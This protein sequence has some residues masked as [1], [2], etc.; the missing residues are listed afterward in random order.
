MNNDRFH[1]Q[2]KEAASDEEYYFYFWCLTLRNLGYIK[3][4]VF[5]PP[6]FNITPKQTY[7]YIKLMKS[8]T[9]LAE[10]TLLNPHTYQ[11]DYVIEWNK[12]AHH[13][14]F[15]ILGGA[16]NYKSKNEVLLL[17]QYRKDKIISVIDTKGAVSFAHA[18]NN[19]TVIKFPINQKLVYQKFGIYVNKVV[20]FA[21]NDKRNCL[22]SKT[23]TPDEY[24]Y[25]KK[26]VGGGYLKVNCIPRTINE[27]LNVK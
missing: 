9:K 8:K 12:S 11:A 6:V 1:I 2:G 25:R 14:F 20:P 3:E 10:N 17:A 7:Q 19:S 26:K 18:R 24:R 21:S 13:I 4:I 16:D 22:F 5:Q 27:F 15:E 23:F